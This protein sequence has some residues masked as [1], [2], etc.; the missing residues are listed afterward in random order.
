MKKLFPYPWHESFWFSWLLVTAIYL[1][2]A[3]AG[4]LGVYQGT[5]LG[6]IA[7]FFGLLTPIGVFSFFAALPGGG[8]I[9]F[10]IVGAFLFCTDA[11][12]RRFAFHPLPKIFFNLGVLFV[13]TLLTDL[14]LY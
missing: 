14:I 10:Y 12:V 8:A 6:Y 4:G 2:L 13:L 3:A 9:V 1:A 7:G 5:A 11:L